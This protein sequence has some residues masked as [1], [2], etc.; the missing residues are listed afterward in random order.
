M[1]LFGD[2]YYFCMWFLNIQDYAIILKILNLIILFRF[3]G[4]LIFVIG[5]ILYSILR[6]GYWFGYKKNKKSKKQDKSTE[7]KQVD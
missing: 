2:H 3:G 7:M 1:H 5:V 4:L 6:I